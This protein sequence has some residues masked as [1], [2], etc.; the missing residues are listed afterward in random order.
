[1]SLMLGQCCLYRLRS[2][3][4]HAWAERMIDVLRKRS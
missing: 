3:E 4:V 2:A 1:M